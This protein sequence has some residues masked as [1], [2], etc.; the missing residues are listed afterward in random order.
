MNISNSKEIKHRLL[1]TF[2]SLYL[3]LFAVEKVYPAAEGE[4]NP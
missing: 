4:A 2:L 3:T 1:L